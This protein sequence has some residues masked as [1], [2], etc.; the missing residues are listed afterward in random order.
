[1]KKAKNLREARALIG[2]SEIPTKKKK[3]PVDLEYSIIAFARD[4]NFTVHP[5]GLTRY[6]ESYME[7]SYCPCDPARKECPC[8]ESIDEVN[9]VGHCKCRLYWKDLNTYI[10]IQMQ[11][12]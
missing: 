1:M 2:K 12:E 6:A 9:T 3:I 11:K 10:K 8:A 5:L 7:F 4:H